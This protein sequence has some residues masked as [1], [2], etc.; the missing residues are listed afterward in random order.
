MAFR[1]GCIIRSTLPTPIDPP[2]FV[3]Q[4]GSDASSRMRVHVVA[5][6]HVEDSAEQ[7]QEVIKGTFS[8]TMKKPAIQRVWRRRQEA[9]HASQVDKVDIEV[10]SESSHGA[11]STS[12]AKGYA[13]R[14]RWGKVGDAI[15]RSKNQRK[16]LRPESTPPALPSSISKE[17]E[18]HHDEQD[19]LAHA[20]TTQTE[21]STVCLEDFDFATWRHSHKSDDSTLSVEN[22]PRSMSATLSL[23]YWS[24][25][26]KSFYF[27]QPRS[28]SANI[29]KQ[30]RQSLPTRRASMDKSSSK[31]F[32]VSGTEL[33]MRNKLKLASRVETGAGA[34]H[35]QKDISVNVEN[36]SKSR[37]HSI[38]LDLT[39]NEAF[40][41]TSEFFFDDEDDYIIL[42]LEDEVSR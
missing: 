7:T 18:M 41:S 28:R 30:T 39:N 23:G 17:L 13:E 2:S 19:E 37:K 10:E 34:V 15:R 38:T 14:N 24:K 4:E 42:Q 1:G 3:R 31:I 26:K 6:P 11:S 29:E 35:E 27:Q 33:R 8:G 20:R 5:A 22:H 40:A 9:V 25:K 32:E 16:Y 36:S 12:A 21:V